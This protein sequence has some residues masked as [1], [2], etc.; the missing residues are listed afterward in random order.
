M[1]A[2]GRHPPC[3][4]RP[5]C[6]APR[7]PATSAAPCAHRQGDMR[8]AP[9]S[10]HARIAKATCEAPLAAPCSQPPCAPISALRPVPRAQA[11]SADVKCWTSSAGRLRRTTTGVFCLSPTDATHPGTGAPSRQGTWHRRPCEVH[12]A[13][14]PIRTPSSRRRA[15][16]WENKKNVNTRPRFTRNATSFVQAHPFSIYSPTLPN[17]RD[18]TLSSRYVSIHYLYVLYDIYMHSTLPSSLFHMFR[19][20]L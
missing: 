6:Q 2:H 10:P 5:T 3:L 4:G 16:P 17:V 13:S 1:P 8:S 12:H 9:G 19:D 7:R 15:M 20:V 18:L 11:T 14:S